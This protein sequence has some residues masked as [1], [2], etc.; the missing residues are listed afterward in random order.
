MLVL[1]ANRDRNGQQIRSCQKLST[2]GR[3]RLTSRWGGGDMFFTKGLLSM[4]SCWS[5]RIFATLLALASGCGGDSPNKPPDDEE[6]PKQLHAVDL[7]PAWSPDGTKIAF[8]SSETDTVNWLTD[9]MIVVLHLSTQQRDTV[10]VGRYLYVNSIDWSPDETSLVLSSFYGIQ[11]LEIDSDSLRTIKTG[12][13]HTSASWSSISG[14][15]F[16]S[17]GGGDDDG[18]YSIHSDGSDLR[19]FSYLRHTL[20]QPWV[21]QDSDSLTCIAW[22]PKP[23]CLGILAP[24]DTSFS[25]TVACGLEFPGRVQMHPNHRTVF[26]NGWTRCGVAPLIAIDRLTGIQDTIVTT[27]TL[28][29]DISPDGQWGVYTDRQETGGLHMIN[30]ES[31]EVRQLTRGQ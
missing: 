1:E 7:F 29:Y 27:Y 14:R 8:V 6:C 2:F 23:Y 11:M 26:F 12:E 21:F 19:R 10:L 13:F 5:I 16:F 18:I 30:L 24:G 3:F 20:S 22:N 31:K 4:T 9:E 17:I 15:I 28:D 25:D